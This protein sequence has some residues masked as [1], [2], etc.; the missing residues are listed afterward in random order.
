M[1]ATPD[2]EECARAL[3]A[4]TVA[5]ETTIHIFVPHYNF[6]TTITLP[7]IMHYLN[8]R[9]AARNTNCRGGAALLFEDKIECQHLANTT[10]YNDLTKLQ[11]AFLVSQVLRQLLRTTVHSPFPFST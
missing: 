3:L 1:P 2:G 6:Y 4:L 11:N 5:H 7:D 10:G 8:I 9:G